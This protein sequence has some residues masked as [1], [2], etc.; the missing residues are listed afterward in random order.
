MFGL[1]RIEILIIVVVVLLLSRP[2][3]VPRM[4]RTI[5]RFVGKAKRMADSVQSE[6]RSFT[7]EFELD[8]PE[9]RVEKGSLAANNREE[10][11]KQ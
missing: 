5:G 10:Q 6:V 7:R 11:K 8:E 9:E 2:E 1:G 3:D 4:L